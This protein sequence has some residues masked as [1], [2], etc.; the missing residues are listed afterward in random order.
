MALNI[1]HTYTTSITAT[2]YNDDCVAV[3]Y[4]DVGNMDAI[5]ENVCY[6][7]VK[8]NFK[9]ADVCSQTTGEVLMTIERT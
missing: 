2:F 8:H 3:R 1:K 5:A 9:Y 6:M 7:M 4:D